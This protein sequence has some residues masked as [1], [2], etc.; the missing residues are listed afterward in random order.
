VGWGALAGEQLSSLVWTGIVLALVAIGMVSW[1][2]DDPNQP[3]RAVTVRV[4]GESLLAGCGFGAFFILFDA[5][6]ASSAPWPVVGARLLTTLGFG[7]ALLAQGKRVRPADGTT[8][9]MIAA[10][11]LFDTAANV[12]FLVATLQGDLAIVAVLTSLYPVATAVLA[13]GV[14]GERLNRIQTI[15]F[16]GAL[17]ATALIAAG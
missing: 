10:A 5:T 3:H 2:D 6:D 7:A 17:G 8:A 4:V 9:A 16:A 13:A 1:T 12:G 15:G 11:G 14:L